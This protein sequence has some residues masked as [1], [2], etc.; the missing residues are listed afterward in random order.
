MTRA[1]PPAPNTLCSCPLGGGI[2]GAR[3]AGIS[4]CYPSC[5]FLQFIA[6]HSLHFKARSLSLN[7]T[8]ADYDPAPQSDPIPF[9]W[10]APAS[11]LSGHTRSHMPL[12]Q[13][14]R[15]HT[16]VG[17]QGG[18]SGGRP[19]SQ[20]LFVYCRLLTVVDGSLPT[21]MSFSAPHST[22]HAGFPS[23][24]TRHWSMWSFLLFSL[25]SFDGPGTVDARQ[26]DE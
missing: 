17:P 1:G 15:G 22:L 11:C 25:C 23:S 8:P 19:Y 21:A 26:E 20:S 3:R 2:A 6:R 4:S 24:V 18:R 7:A 9:I 16:S 14:G 12:E 13:L 5:Q 10:S